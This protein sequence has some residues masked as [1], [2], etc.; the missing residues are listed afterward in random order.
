MA[1][2]DDIK[3]IANGH[4]L[5]VYEYEKAVWSDFEG[6]GGRRGKDE[7]PSER[8]DENRRLTCRRAREMIRRICLANFDERSKF[9]TLTY[10]ENQTDVTQAN[11]DFKKF[12]QRLRYKYKDFK[13]VAVIEF[14]E[15]GA[16]HY[17]MMS[18]LPYIPNEQLNGLWKMGYVKINDINHVDNVGAYMIKYMLKDTSDPRLRG[19]KAYLTSR[20]LDRPSVIRGEQARKIKDMY[21]L[22]NKKIVFTN[23]YESEHHG[24]IIYKEYNL[25][26]DV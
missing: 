20:G 14:Q 24:K 16:V 25:K 21:E 23:S 1:K 19:K 2:K 26:R 5:E 12:I 9:I 22:D 7:E 17:H 3:I 18:D 13:Y 15:R 8:A 4:V 11:G 6:Q 10:A